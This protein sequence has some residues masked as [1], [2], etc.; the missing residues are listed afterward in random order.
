MVDDLVRRLKSKDANER[1]QAIVALAN[2]GDPRAVEILRK[3][4]ASDPQPVLR[5]IAAKAESHLR[6]KLG[7]S[8]LMPLQASYSSGTALSESAP[9]YTSLSSDRTPSSSSARGQLNN[10]YGAKVNGD[11]A[12]A[13][14]ALMAALDLDPNLSGDPAVR[15]LASDLTGQSPDQAIPY[16]QG[17]MTAGI[18]AGKGASGGTVKS[19]GDVIV[20]L[21]IATIILYVL[22]VCIFYLSLTAAKESPVSV[23]NS[24]SRQSPETVRVLQ[25]MRNLQ[26][27][28]LIVYSLLV[29]GGV[30]VIS[31]FFFCIM[32]V[33]G[34]MMG[35]SASIFEFVTTMF[36]VDAAT[37][38]PLLVTTILT[39]TTLHS[40]PSV[41]NGVSSL[42]N[43]V[44]SV[45]SLASI[46]IYSYYSAKVNEFSIFKGFGT[47]IFPAVFACGCACLLVVLSSGSA[48]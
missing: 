10:A 6:S 20:N 15:Q 40:S 48:R 33:G 38:A 18:A 13:L 11:K 27:S 22:Y 41:Q 47:V 44:N 1:K 4:A 24:L 2:S 5:E 8:T 23:I 17:K 34:L 45:L 16:L 29:S 39:Y 46:A 42:T 31:F 43:L 3:V 21:G 25:Q 36:V 32:Y 26:S 7:Q 14:A 12:G 35:G 37:T 28:Q 19:F 9:D 30:V